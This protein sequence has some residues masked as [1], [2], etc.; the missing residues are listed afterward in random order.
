LGGSNRNG[1]D[2]T[3]GR[4]LCRRIV[5]LADRRS[6]AWPKPS[7][8]A[9][10]RDG[11]PLCRSR[12]GLLARAERALAVV[13]VEAV[14]AMEAVMVVSRR[15]QC[16]LLGTVRPKRTMR[17]V[18]PTQRRNASISSLLTALSL[19]IQTQRIHSTLAAPCALFAFMRFHRAS[20]PSG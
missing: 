9:W 3:G 20:I 5:R 7:V 14:E 6:T 17:G 13:A 1:T 12:K 18:W 4:R 11:S 15:M 10:Q 2:W 16:R 8:T 19:P